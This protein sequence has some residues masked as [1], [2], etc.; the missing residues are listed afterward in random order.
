[1]KKRK[2]Y[3]P[4]AFVKRPRSQTIADELN[5]KAAHTCKHGRAVECWDKCGVV[6]KVLGEPGAADEGLWWFAMSL[7]E[8][9]QHRKVA[10]KA[11]NPWQNKG[12]RSRN[13]R[14]VSWGK[15]WAKRNPSLL[16][17][18]IISVGALLWNTILAKV[19]A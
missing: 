10:Q 17:A 11:R 4:V 18:G 8:R 12:V 3:R 7:E 2:R 15:R 19:P 13:R 16:G 6:C 5:K 1:M 9:D 14:R